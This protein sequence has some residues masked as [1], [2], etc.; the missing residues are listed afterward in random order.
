MSNVISIK[1]RLPIAEEIATP[2]S[3]K[4][5]TV[6]PRVKRNA[7]VKT[8]LMYKLFLNSIKVAGLLAMI[9][10]VTSYL[11]YQ[12]YDFFNAIIKSNQTLY[13]ISI[14]ALLNSIV[15]ELILLTSAAYTTSRK[16][17]I[18]ILAWTLM[19]GMIGGLGVFMHASINND[20]T[21]N[22]D[23]VQSLKQQRKD[24][25]SAKEGYDAEKSALD[26]LKWKSRREL[27]QTKINVERSNI[28]TLD[29]K[30]AEAKEVTTGN[31][32]SIIIY[33][34]IL[35]LAAMVINALLAHTLIS[36]FVK[37]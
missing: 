32:Q 31:L 14:P 3:V 35:R 5:E 6:K 19:L 28:E 16:L 23:F 12:N 22:T 13:G 34:T 9:A 11:V 37:P 18:K 10:G 7:P 1:N 4:E 36:R 27:L 26:P 2:V 20:L 29:K 21:G 25:I 17:Q 24:A 33:N 30:I 15:A 8:N